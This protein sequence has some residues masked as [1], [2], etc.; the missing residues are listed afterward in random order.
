MKKI[1]KTW[2]QPIWI[3]MPNIWPGR[4]I[5]GNFVETKLNKIVK[6]NYQT[7]QCWRVKL[8]K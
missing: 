4:V 7:T 6:Y 3:G 8:K 1:K 2:S 5:G